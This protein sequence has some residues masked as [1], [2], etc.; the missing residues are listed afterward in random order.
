[1]DRKLA[2]HRT[3]VIVDVEGFGDPQ[4]TNR[5]QVA[6]RAG[7]YRAMHDAFANAGIPWDKCDHEDRGDGILILVPAE[8]P[9]SLLVAS[10]PPALVGALQRHNGMQAGQRRI[11]LRMA[12]HAGEV[13]YDDYGVTGTSINLAFRWFGSGLARFM[14]RA[15]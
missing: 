5:H 11:R 12:L 6:V 15:C 1:V 10:L 2:V 13:N 9:K 8:V 3:I 14:S 7:L 4:R